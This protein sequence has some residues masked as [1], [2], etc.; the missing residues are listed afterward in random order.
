MPPIKLGDKGQ[1]NEM[2]AAGNWSAMRSLNLLMRFA[3]GLGGFGRQGG[4]TCT[5]KKTDDIT[6][7]E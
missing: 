7:R 5:K 4:L 1:G 6:E 3:E 2:L